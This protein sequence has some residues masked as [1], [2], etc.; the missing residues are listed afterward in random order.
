MRNHRWEMDE[1]RENRIGERRIIDALGG[2]QWEGD[3]EEEENR[4]G[5]KK[6]VGARD[7][8]GEH[9]K[10]KKIEIRMI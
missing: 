4:K 1:Y 5:E 6:D 2:E 3:E 10:K 7:R 8:E 9:S